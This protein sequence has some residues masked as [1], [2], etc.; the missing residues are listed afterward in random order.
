MLHSDRIAVRLCRHGRAHGTPVPLWPSQVPGGQPGPVQRAVC[1]EPL[2][3]AP[4]TLV[5]GF[6]LLGNLVTAMD[7]QNRALRGSLTRCFGG[8][9][10][11]WSGQSPL[12]LGGC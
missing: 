2:R 6:H 5:S 4:F 3:P 11:S 1:F 8:F 9:T 12:C 10:G 7:L